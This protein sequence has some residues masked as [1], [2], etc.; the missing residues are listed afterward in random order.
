MATVAHELGNGFRAVEVLQRTGAEGG[1]SVSRHIEDLRDCVAEHG[2]GRPALILGHSWGGMLALAYGAAYPDGLGG[3]ML[4]G[5]GTFDV[6]S[7]R[8][9][10][11]LRNER[12][13]E[14]GRAMMA[15]LVASSL[16]AADRMKREAGLL[17]KADSHDLAELGSPVTE[18]DPDG[19]DGSWGDMIAKQEGGTYPAAYAAITCPVLMLHGEQDPHPGE[20]IRD[21]LKPHLPQLEYVELERCGHYPWLERHARDRFYELAREWLLLQPAL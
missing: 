3:I 15:R 19:H 16:S 10:A 11:E 14:S 1:L 6:Q 20:M 12:L 18:F 21:S 9:L 5:S 8:R 4:V 13:G 2:A 7:R 17:F